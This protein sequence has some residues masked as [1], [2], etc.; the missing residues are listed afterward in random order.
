[1][2]V[3]VIIDIMVLNFIYVLMMNQ[4]YLRLSQNM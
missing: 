3:K 1:M 4:M 2:Y